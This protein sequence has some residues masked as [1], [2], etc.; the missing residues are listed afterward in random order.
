MGTK[1]FVFKNSQRTLGTDN[2]TIQPNHLELEREIN[3][4]DLSEVQLNEVKKDIH[5]D[6]LIDSFLKKA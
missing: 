2:L 1:I 6:K 5:N 3:L 4:E